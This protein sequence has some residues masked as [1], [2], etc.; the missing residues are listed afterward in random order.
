M[1]QSMARIV[2]GEEKQVMVTG[3]RMYSWLEDESC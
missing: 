3:W 2:D 1:Y